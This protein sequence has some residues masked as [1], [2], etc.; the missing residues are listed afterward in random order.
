MKNPLTNA[1]EY[2]GDTEYKGYTHRRPGAPKPEIAV[3][4]PP[5]DRGR[6]GGIVAR[7]RLWRART[8]PR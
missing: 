1:K 5:V 7:G 6:V 4:R 2:K 8:S 3:S